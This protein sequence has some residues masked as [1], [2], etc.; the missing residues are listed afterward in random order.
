MSCLHLLALN[1]VGR[2]ANCDISVGLP[3]FCDIQV[4][5]PIRKKLEKQCVLQRDFELNCCNYLILI[6]GLTLS[7]PIISVS[8]LRG[9]VGETLTPEVAM[10]YAAAFASTIP[11]GDILV[12]RD[13]RPS[14][15]MLS[16]AIHAALQALGRN[17][18]DAGIVAMPTA[19]A[20][21]QIVPKE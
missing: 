7:E 12:G 21:G 10:R 19:G 18:I 6:L 4:N 9:I 3:F 8:G 11:P 17:T 15:R 1:G 2:Q 16:L 14:G 13:S 20:H 5:R